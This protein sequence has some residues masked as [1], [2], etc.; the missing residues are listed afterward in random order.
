MEL[1]YSSEC[2]DNVVSALGYFFLIITVSRSVQKVTYYLREKKRKILLAKILIR[3]GWQE[4]S[5][6]RRSLALKF[7]RDLLNGR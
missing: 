5:M 1:G 4:Y 2:N 3:N 7:V 6:P